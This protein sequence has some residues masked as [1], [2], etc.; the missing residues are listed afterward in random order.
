MITEKN[1]RDILQF[2]EERSHS[3]GRAYFYVGE[4][5]EFLNSLSSE[6]K[7]TRKIYQTAG[8]WDCEDCEMCGNDTDIDMAVELD[9]FRL[10]GGGG[11]GG[12]ERTRAEHHA[13]RELLAGYDFTPV[14]YGLPPNPRVSLAT[15]I[16]A[17]DIRSMRRIPVV[18]TETPRRSISQAF[19]DWIGT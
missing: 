7:H 9:P 14:R 5:A 18:T 2:A 19:M 1:I 17:E 15:S 3:T 4:L 8:A 6:C 11:G 13:R 10:S 16:S 12:Y